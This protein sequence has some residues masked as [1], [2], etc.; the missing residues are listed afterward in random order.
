MVA[1]LFFEKQHLTLSHHYPFQDIHSPYLDY[2]YTICAC[3][4]AIEAVEASRPSII[5]D[6]RVISRASDLMN[7]DCMVDHWSQRWS[8]GQVLTFW[9]RRS[10]TKR[11]LSDDSQSQ[12]S[13]VFIS[14]NVAGKQGWDLWTVSLRLWF[15]LPLW[16]KRLKSSIDWAKRAVSIAV[17]S[18][19]PIGCQCFIY[20]QFGG[21]A[22]EQHFI[23]HHGAQPASVCTSSSAQPWLQQSSSSSSPLT[24]PSCPP[25]LHAHGTLCTSCANVVER[26]ICFLQQQSWKRLR[27]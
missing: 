21:S 8:D 26:L 7:P 1:P 4:R 9:G 15:N 22:G 25:L 5:H 12:Q 27:S 3:A 19:M 2:V 6:V 14:Q 24:V 16:A 20:K 18:S 13:F 17:F 23:K 10:N 11:P